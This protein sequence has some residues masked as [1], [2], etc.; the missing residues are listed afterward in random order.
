MFAEPTNYDW[1]AIKKDWYAKW[2]QHNPRARVRLQKSPTDLARVAMLQREFPGARFIVMARN[3]FA[4]VDGVLRGNPAA[5][6]EQAGRAALRWVVPKQLES[7]IDIGNNVK[8][9]L[10]SSL[11]TRDINKAFIAMRDMYTGIFYVNAPTIGAEVHLPFGGT[12]ETG[13]GHREAGVAGIDV[14][15]E[16]KSVYVDYSGALQRAQLDTEEI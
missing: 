6:I 7:G 10:S 11:Y 1:P 4:V 13:N 16:W 8:Y 12:K 14:F 3:P 15:S 9:G 2:D 5:T